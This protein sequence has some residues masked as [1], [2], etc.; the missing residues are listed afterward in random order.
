MGARRGL[1]AVLALGALAASAHG[2]SIAMVLLLQFKIIRLLEQPWSAIDS[3]AHFYETDFLRDIDNDFTIAASVVFSLMQNFRH[4]ASFDSMYLAR[5]SDGSFVGYFNKE[6]ANASYEMSFLP[7]WDCPWNYTAAC[8]GTAPCPEGY[9]GANPAC[10][11]GVDAGDA[12]GFPDCAGWTIGSCDFLDDTADHRDAPWY[13]GAMEWTARGVA[14]TWSDIDEF[15]AGDPPGGTR[16]MRRDFNGRARA[17]SRDSLGVGADERTRLVE[18][19]A[20]TT[21]M[22]PGSRAFR[23][24]GDL[25][26]TATRVYSGDDLRPAMTVSVDYVLQSI[27][28]LVHTSTSTGDV[29]YVIEEESGLLVAVSEGSRVDAD[30]ERVTPYGSDNPAIV[31]SSAFLA[32][33]GKSRRSYYNVYWI[34]DVEEDDGATIKYWAV[35]LPL[36]TGQIGLSWATTTPARGPDDLR[37]LRLPDEDR[38]ADAA[39]VYAC[40]ACEPGYY[41]VADGGAYACEECPHGGVCEGGT[42]QPYPEEGFWGLRDHPTEFQR[43]ATLRGRAGLRVLRRLQRPPVRAH[44]QRPLPGRGHAVPVP[45]V[46]GARR[47]ATL[48]MVLTVFAL[49]HVINAVVCETSDVTDMLLM[50][51]QQCAIVFEFDLG[52][53]AS[54]SYLEPLFE[55]ALFDVDLVQPNCVVTGWTY[56]DGFYVQLV[57]PL[58]YALSYFLPIAGASPPRGFARGAARRGVRR[59][60]LMRAPEVRCGTTR[61]NVMRAFAGL[62]I[63]GVVVGFP[64][65][66]AAI[67]T[68]NNMRYEGLHVPHVLARYGAFYDRYH[69]KYFWDAWLTLRVLLLV[70][71]ATQFTRGAIQARINDIEYGFIGLTGAFALRDVR[72]VVAVAA[73]LNGNEIME[74]KASTGAGDGLRAHLEGRDSKRAR[75]SAIFDADYAKRSLMLSAPRSE[76]DDELKLRHADLVELFATLDGFLSRDF[77]ARVD[78]DQLLL[79]GMSRAL[80]PYTCDESPTSVYNRHHR[81]HFWRRLLAQFP[82]LIDFAAERLKD[83]DVREAFFAHLVALERF[84][85]TT[86]SDRGHAVCEQ[87]RSSVLY[88]LLAAPEA[89]RAELVAVLDAFEAAR[90]A[91]G[92]TAHRSDGDSPR[93]HLLSDKTAA[94]APPPPRTPRGQARHDLETEMRARETDVIAHL[95]RRFS[96]DRRDD[97]GDD[98]PDAPAEAKADDARGALGSFSDGPDEP[99]PPP[100]RPP[101]PPT[102]RLEAAPPPRTRRFRSWNGGSTRPRSSS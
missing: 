31:T 80:A 81:A 15:T 49:W 45:G 27:D 18:A 57:L 16:T 19:S 54:L 37:A 85:G 26:I 6:N 97:D 91:T 22:R 24:T 8:N 2:Q 30:G 78:Y 89:S 66:I 60:F 7:G 99:P 55:V 76:E 13:T 20:E 47:A 21:S 90:A 102:A 79:C 87:D 36:V 14:A 83:P 32:G 38:A 46:P 84:L 58:V 69:T 72:L 3:L 29:A 1:R 101:P 61:H 100:G 51:V 28:D 35:A 34:I 11:H 95:V 92:A 23:R 48:A 86:T 75:H 44:G 43:A 10:R 17:R 25:G 42:A 82:G 67:L 70:V 65:F 63:A 74:K 73:Y 5:D 50:T 59:R 62:Y 12:R 77:A 71:V 39:G 33:G 64:L 88:Y 68:R 98:G 93:H 56:Y 96:A 41:V 94:A 40:D 52:W 4:D 9:P 53:P